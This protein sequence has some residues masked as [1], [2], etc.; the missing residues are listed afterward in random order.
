VETSGSSGNDHQLL[1]P[2][3]VIANGTMTDTPIDTATAIDTAI[4][5]KTASV[6]AT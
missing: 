6:T 4:V 3:R 2:S 5:S 1:K